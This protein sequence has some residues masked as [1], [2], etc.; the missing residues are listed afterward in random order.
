M[1][2]GVYRR[3]FQYVA[4]RRLCAMATMIGSPLEQVVDDL[5]GEPQHASASHNRAH[6][7]NARMRPRRLFN[8]LQ[9][10]VQ[11]RIEA[12]TASTSAL[13]LLVL[14][15]RIRTVQQRFVAVP[16]HRA[17]RRAGPGVRSSWRETRP[18][19]RR[20][21]WRTIR[22]PSA[23]DTMSAGVAMRR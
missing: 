11:R 23:I 12:R 9:G 6:A 14:R 13:V 18:R 1:T 22:S 15:D 21:S 5:V 7:G 10:V 3:F 4:D 20:S 17:A 8:A 2:M 16:L 19:R